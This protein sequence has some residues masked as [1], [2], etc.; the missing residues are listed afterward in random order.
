MAEE[1]EKPKIKIGIEGFDPLGLKSAGEIAKD[2][3]KFGIDSAKAFLKLTC[4]PLLEEIGLMLRDQFTNWKLNNILKMLEKADGKLSYDPEK[5]KLVIDP[6]VA[7]QI[8]E[9]ASIVGN[10]TLQDM[11]A[12]LFASSC[13]KY[14]ED[15]NILFI[16][17]LK[18][19]TSSQVKLLNYLCEKSKKD[20]GGTLPNYRDSG[21]V[22]S[23]GVRVRYE[24]LLLIMET[25]SK[26][27]VDTEFSAL[28]NMGLITHA[29][30]PAVNQT[31]LQVTKSEGSWGGVKPTLMAVR[32]Y[33]K[34]QGSRDTPYNYFLAEIEEHYFELLKNVFQ[35]EKH[36]I[37][38]YMYTQSERGE[39]YKG[40]I[41]FGSGG[42]KIEDESWLNFSKDELHDRLSSYLIFRHISG[43]DKTWNIEISNIDF[44]TFNHKSG[45]SKNTPTIER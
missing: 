27:K 31:L 20:I 6:R 19:L 45:I 32:L 40:K 18:R 2:A 15:E 14:E 26:L 5:E 28:E 7:Y 24:D 35:V 25:D 30:R 17:I 23:S 39:K 41:K 21:L 33:V 43:I 42:F 44:G 34:C 9:H 13:Q 8:V 3:T 12:G 29:G 16:D 1:N 38:D 37:L 22:S 10:E 36:L 11:W 4:K